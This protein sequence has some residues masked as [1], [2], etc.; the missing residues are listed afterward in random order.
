MKYQSVPVILDTLNTT[1]EDLLSDNPYD[2]DRNGA[3][4]R[5]VFLDFSGK[6]GEPITVNMKIL[7]PDWSR[8]ACPS[9]LTANEVNEYV[10]RCRES[11]H[12]EF[13]KYEETSYS[14]KKGENNTKER[15]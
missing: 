11:W 14:D 3:K 15:A 10:R 9:K 2:D 12:N 5:D 1:R 8:S 13:L 4:V 6:Q 7:L